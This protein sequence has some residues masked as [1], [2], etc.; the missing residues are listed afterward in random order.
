MT[1]FF[2]FLPGSRAAREANREDARMRR[3]ATARMSEPSYL[4][5]LYAHNPVLLKRALAAYQNV[6]V[7]ALAKLNVSDSSVLLEPLK[8]ALCAFADGLEEVR[9]RD[10]QERAA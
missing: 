8:R 7:E 9:S 4:I 6:P 3:E 2:R 10:E 1:D 5:K